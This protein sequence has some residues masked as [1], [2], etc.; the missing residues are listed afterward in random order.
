MA[1]SNALFASSRS[2]RS[3][4]LFAAATILMELATRSR[5]S[6]LLR[7]VRDDAQR[8]VHHRLRKIDLLAVAPAFLQPQRLD[9]LTLSL[10]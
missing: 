6:I 10:R 1:T 7:A 9:G 5:F 8:Q 4:G 3:L 2:S